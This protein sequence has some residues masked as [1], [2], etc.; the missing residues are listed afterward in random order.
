MTRKGL[1]LYSFDELAERLADSADHRV[2]RRLPA[3]ENISGGDA[4]LYE[5]RYLDVET[6]GLNVDKDEIIELAVVPFLF[7]HDGL[8]TCVK[9][10]AHCYNEPSK[11]I[12]EDIESLTGVSNEMVKGKRLDVEFFETVLGDADLILAHNARFDRQMVE[13]YLPT[14]AKKCWGCSMEEVPWPKRGKRLEYIVQDMGYFYDAHSAVDDCF[15]GLF[16]LRQDVGGRSGFAYALDSAR[17]ATWHVWTTGLKYDEDVNELLKERGYKF[18]NGQDGRPKAWHKVIDINDVD[19]ESSWLQT[20]A[21]G[22]RSSSARFDKINAFSRY[23]KR[24]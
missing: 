15:A 20:N 14:A 11:S 12:S 5:G 8:I 10:A 3:H 21:Y 9:G 17:R 19:E 6:T 2:L 24:E 18:N 1:S 7:T 13:R 4:R 16:A 23:S 22:N